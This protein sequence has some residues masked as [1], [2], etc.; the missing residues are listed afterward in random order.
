MDNDGDRPALGPIE[1]SFTESEVSE[2]GLSPVDHVL[3]T[4]CSTLAWDY[5]ELWTL[6][7]SREK[8]V[9][10]A[11]ADATG[12]L[13]DFIAV[14]T[15]VAFDPGQGTPGRVWA[16]NQPEWTLLH[17]TDS[18]EEYIRRVS[19]L[20]AGLRC[21]LGVPV[22]ANGSKHGVLV[23]SARDPDSIDPA[24][25]AKTGSIATSLGGFLDDSSQTNSLARRL[26]D[27]SLD[28]FYVI[29]VETAKV[30]DVNQAACDQLG[31]TREELLSC[32]VPEFDPEFTMERWLDFAE[33]VEE[34]GPIT[35]ETTH[36]HK[37]G[38][39]FPVEIQVTRVDDDR[40]YHVAT[41]RDISERRARERALERERENLRQT[42]L[43]TNAGGWVY[44][45]ESETLE[46]TEGTRR[47]FGL[48]D[49]L[50]WTLEDSFQYYHTDDRDDFVA[51]FK[52]CL[53]EGTPYEMEVRIETGTGEHKWI[54][55]H[56][57][58]QQLD[59]REVVRGAVRDI[60][61]QKEREQQLERSERRYRQ[62][63]E[64]MPN[65]AVLLF[66]E[67]LRYTLAHG[68]GL[69]AHGP[70]PEA[71]LG[72]HVTEMVEG[73]LGERLVEL[74]ERTLDG[75]AVGTEI[76]YEDRIFQVETV[77]LRNADD[78]VYA[79]MV[80]TQDVTDLRRSER[81][82]AGINELARELLGT[83]TDTEVCRHA[84]ELAHDL[85]DSSGV[86]I[87]LYD[88][89][90]ESL[91][92]AA[93]TGTAT[94]TIGK[95]PTFAA[96][97]GL[98]WEVFT[99]DEMA[100][101]EDVRT[102]DGVYNPGTPIRSE[103]ILP[104]GGHGVAIVGS[105][106]VDA[107]DE[108]DVQ[109][110]EALAS[111]VA[112]ALDRAAQMSAL[113][114]HRL[115]L[116][117]KTEQL[118]QVNRLNDELRSLMRSLI[119]ATTTEEVFDALCA[120]VAD[121]DGIEASWVGRPGRDAGAL[122]VGATAGSP[123][124]AA[125]TLAELAERE[126]D[127]PPV[128]ALDAESIVYEPFIGDGV[129]GSEWRSA[130]LIY[131]IRSMVSV[132]LSSGELCYGVLTIHAREQ[133][134]FDEETRSILREIGEFAGYALRAAE[135]RQS[136]LGSPQF[137]RR[138]DIRGLSGT[139]IE[140]ARD[141]GSTVELDWILK[142]DDDTHLVYFRIDGVSVT[143]IVDLAEQTPEIGSI[144]VLSD[145][146]TRYVQAVV[147][148]TC[149]VI[150]LTELAVNIRTA[151]VHADRCTIRAMTPACL[152]ESEIITRI[153]SLAPGVSVTVSTSHEPATPSI[154]LDVFSNA[155]T[156]RQQDILAA[157]FYGGYF[158]DPRVCTGNEIADRL[159]ISQPSFSKQLRAAQRN[160]YRQLI[161]P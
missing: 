77:P 32:T 79:G 149:R 25:Q 20:D 57:E 6:D 142:R 3:E 53:T 55:E 85:F 51:A 116:E 61:E 38:H 42:E 80:L 52:R 91:V 101:F 161:E 129:A 50:E 68:Q 104:L 99:R 102:A 138:F 94:E 157:A 59:D 100:V 127:V 11:F 81:S 137:T 73:D 132:P 122:T 46:I 45:I 152:D 62:L 44:D 103:I 75:S 88:H 27:D 74:Y 139:F 86:A 49:D 92:P 110:A 153:E 124:S 134:A 128:R 156:D 90:V 48:S 63:A 58:R 89:D 35:I 120:S 112:A 141:L 14:T 106:I 97:E 130:A 5:A 96:G 143:R 13:S 39:T 47:V 65:G 145:G 109:I 87:Y 30:L 95:L 19:A 123:V 72:A 155:L 136:I 21:V 54:H 1:R 26:L 33:T 64:N 17:D 83:D 140:F 82:V 9:C 160:L 114:Q 41:V 93:Q 125:T 144:E 15:T 8:L 118:T 10:R 121:V 107:F 22:T 113:H 36:Q 29:D 67:D 31:Y 12:S 18:S 2:P 71:Y 135:Q 40:A 119:R 150:A 159:G 98:A 16:S 78:S 70:P 84:V 147:H 115:E 37:D 126:T 158:E 131:D 34:S 43:L 7:R 60:T 117:Q 105:S 24:L 154:G 4:I 76:S 66:D 151:T 28:G 108:L 148:G 23:C 56:G 133:D 146:E 111:T 69:L